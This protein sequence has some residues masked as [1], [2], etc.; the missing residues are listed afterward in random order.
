MAD[1]VAVKVE[2]LVVKLK[3]AVESVGEC[4]FDSA[5]TASGNKP[6]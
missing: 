6:S 5:A 2:N 3:P 4:D 1:D